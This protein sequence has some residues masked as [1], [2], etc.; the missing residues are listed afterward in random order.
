MY[1][2]MNSAAPQNPIISMGVPKTLLLAIPTTLRVL[3]AMRLREALVSTIA[4]LI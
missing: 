4:L 2:S 3:R 1:P